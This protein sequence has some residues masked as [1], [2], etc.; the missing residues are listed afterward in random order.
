M[1]ISCNHSNQYFDDFYLI[2]DL[3]NACIISYIHSIDIYEYEVSS[4]EFQMQSKLL[5]YYLYTLQCK[6]TF[7]LIQE[8]DQLKAI[9]NTL[10]VKMMPNFSISY[11]SLCKVSTKK[12]FCILQQTKWAICNKL[13]G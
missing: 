11:R 4:S 12:G 1:Q 8:F 6:I 3:V 10:K 7:Q 5:F 2:F 9:Y 13:K